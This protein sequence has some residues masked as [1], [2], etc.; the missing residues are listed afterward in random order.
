[1]CSPGCQNYSYWRKPE[2]VWYKYTLFDPIRETWSQPLTHPW[3]SDKTYTA[4][5]QHMMRWNML[6]LNRVQPTA[7]APGEQWSATC[8]AQGNLSH[9]C[10]Q[11]SNAQP[12]P[13][14]TFLS[15][16][17][18]EPVGYD[19]PKKADS[20]KEYRPIY[21]LPH[22]LYLAARRKTERNKRKSA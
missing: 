14:P 3:I 7:V 1:M 11:D 9:G 10:G 2:E 22:S 15:P 5:S 12:V 4:H 19:Y 16:R 18:E 17:M 6:T 20:Q 13:L 21:A 8:L